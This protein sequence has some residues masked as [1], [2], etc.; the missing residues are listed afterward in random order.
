MDT[1]RSG[2]SARSTGTH[3][4]GTS[5]RSGTSRKT[6]DY[7]GGT[8]TD[9]KPKPLPRLGV[10]YDPPGALDCFADGT[11]PVGRTL[12]ANWVEASATPKVVKRKR[13][14]MEPALLDLVHGLLKE[15]TNKSMGHDWTDL[16]EIADKDASG[17]LELDELRKLVRTTLR[18]PPSDMSNDMVRQLFQ[19]LDYNGNGSIETHE[20]E[21]FLTQGSGVV[22][23]ERPPPEAGSPG[24]PDEKRWPVEANPAAGAV[25]AR[26]VDRPFLQGHLREIR[27]DNKKAEASLRDKAIFELAK[28]TQRGLSTSLGVHVEMTAVA[29]VARL[30]VQHEHVPAADVDALPNAAE[31]RKAKEV[32]KAVRSYNL[33][34]VA[35]LMDVD[36]PRAPTWG[37]V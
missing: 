7:E 10:G 4:S 31:I 25:R 36:V 37:G 30:A 18:I 27:M 11:P 1:A 6:H 13:K 29:N 5:N 12:S 33:K 3:R 23:V 21:A 34:K 16:F 26:E 24:S 9:E 35:A 20:F 22:D 17:T 14:T 15:A 19:V 32:L 28:Q 2:R 8:Y